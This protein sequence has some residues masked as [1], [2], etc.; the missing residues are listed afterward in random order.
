[1]TKCP[2]LCGS[3][4]PAHMFWKEEEQAAGA[5]VGSVGPRAAGNAD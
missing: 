4:T 3:G 2:S 5:E 1:M